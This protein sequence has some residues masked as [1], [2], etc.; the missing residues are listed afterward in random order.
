MK[1]RP[2][3]LVRLIPALLVCL[4]P[5]CCLAQVLLSPPTPPN[6]PAD[7]QQQVVPG[8]SNSPEQQKKPY[9][10]LISADGFRNDLADKYQASNLLRLREGGVAAAAMKPSF[11]TLTFPNHYSLVTGLYPSHHGLVDNA[12]F[13]AKKNGPLFIKDR[14]AVRDG[15]WYGGTLIW[16]LAEQQQMLTASFFAWGP[17]FKQHLKIAAFENV[18]VYPLIAEILGLRSTEK[19]DGDPATLKN[20]L[21]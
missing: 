18:A 7:L 8:R 3:F 5:E 11:P 20:I 1:F 21:R 2:A 17:A 19:I 14:S 15:S 4:T 12:F 6:D 9:I 16:V 10:I 13:D